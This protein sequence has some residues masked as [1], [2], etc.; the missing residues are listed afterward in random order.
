MRNIR[1]F[2]LTAQRW[3][4]IAERGW[5]RTIFA[6][7]GSAYIEAAVAFSLLVSMMVGVLEISLA[8]YTLHFVAEAAREA[9]RFAIVRGSS[10]CSN[11]PNLS[12]CNATS[13]QI[14]TW[15]K[16]LQ[17]PG[18]DPSN[19]TVTASWPSSGASCYPSTAPC[20]NPGNIVNVN[21]MYSFPLNVPFYGRSSI[22]LQ[23]SSQMVISQ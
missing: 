8:F 17:F 3:Q 16:G 23:S 13:D 7:T 12:Y 18:I 1:Q 2:G 21:V 10:S 20:N 4:T 22:N 9:S 15:V 11:S 14:A 19:L 6:Q 5:F